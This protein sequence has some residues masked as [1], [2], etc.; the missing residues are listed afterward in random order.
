MFPCFSFCCTPNSIITNASVF[1]IFGNIV[2][3][4]IIIFAD[5]YYHIVRKFMEWFFLTAI[6]TRSPFINHISHIV[7]SGSQKQMRRIYTSTIITRM[8]NKHTR[9]N[10]TIVDFIRKAGGN[11]PFSTPSITM[12]S[13]IPATRHGSDPIPTFV[14]FS[15][16][17][18]KPKSFFYHK[19]KLCSHISPKVK[20]RCLMLFRFLS[21]EQVFS[22]KQRAFT[23]KIKKTINSLDKNN[24]NTTNTIFQYR[25]L[26]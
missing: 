3:P 15:Y 26:Q 5:F 16:I 6:F 9:R 19:T 12:D 14:C 10:W 17:N 24:C 1:C 2:F 22:T 4:R 25:R 8:T 18:M 20:A 11:N 23:R 21:R 7:I 13:S